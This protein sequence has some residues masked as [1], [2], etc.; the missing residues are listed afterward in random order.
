MMMILM[1]MM[2]MKTKRMIVIH[3]LIKMIILI[4]MIM[5][6]IMM[7]MLMMLMMR[8]M[9]CRNSVG[10][11]H[12]EILLSLSYNPSISRLSVN[13]LEGK[14][15]R[16]EFTVW[17]LTDYLRRKSGCV[18]AH[19]QKSGPQKQSGR[20]VHMHRSSLVALVLMRKSSNFVYALKQS[21]CVSSNFVYALKQSG[22]VSAHAQKQSGRVSAH[23]QKQ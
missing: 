8:I 19:A 22:C 4:L 14:D 2:M 13:V 5:M 23:A 15:I 11:A 1:I 10:S 16:S 3:T 9:C 21:G 18:D 7:L 12:S 17:T 6:T 20:V